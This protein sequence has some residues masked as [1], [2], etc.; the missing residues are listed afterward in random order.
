MTL[1]AIF[2]ATVD[3]ILGRPVFTGREKQDSSQLA[4]KKR[5]NEN[6]ITNRLHRFKI[7]RMDSVR[8]CLFLKH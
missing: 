1:D 4:D 7:N 6:H 5:R 3:A 2:D 8:I